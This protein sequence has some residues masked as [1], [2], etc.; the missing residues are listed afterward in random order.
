MYLEFLILI[1]DYFSTLKLRIFIYEWIFPLLVIFTI[2]IINK[3]DFEILKSFKDSSINILG[4]LLGFSIAVITIITTGSGDNL[5]AIKNTKTDT[6]INNKKITLYDLILINYSYTVIVEVVIILACLI[7]PIIAN[8]LT[9]SLKCKM[10]LYY[11]LIFGVI[12][13][14]LVTLR[15]LTDFYLIITKKNK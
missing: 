1:F 10:N 2:L 12:H 4:I 9:L 13:I 11:L 5:D 7:T 3:N 14:L 15:N 6:I 8:G